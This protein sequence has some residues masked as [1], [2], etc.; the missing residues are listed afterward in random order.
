MILKYTNHTKEKV[1]EVIQSCKTNEQLRGAHKYYMLFMRLYKISA[2]SEVAK[3]LQTFYNLKKI[4]LKH[5]R[6]Y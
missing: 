5:G 4:Q 2:T 6:E 3:K 1:Y